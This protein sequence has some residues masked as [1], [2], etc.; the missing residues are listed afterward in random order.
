[1]YDKPSLSPGNKSHLIMAY[2]L[3]NVLLNFIRSY[4]VEDFYICV[5]DEVT[6]CSNHKIFYN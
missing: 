3:F 4:F 5:Q 1:M 2:D 6:G